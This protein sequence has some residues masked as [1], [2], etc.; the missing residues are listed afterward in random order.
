MVC[1]VYGVW[2]ALHRFW[3]FYLGLVCDYRVVMKA[4]YMAILLLILSSG[5]GY[6]EAYGDIVLRPLSQAPEILPGQGYV[7]ET[8]Y[9]GVLPSPPQSCSLDISGYVGDTWET[10]IV[11]WTCGGDYVEVVVGYRVAEMPRAGLT[12]H[13]MFVGTATADGEVYRLAPTPLH[14][15]PLRIVNH[16]YVSVEAGGYAELYI[17]GGRVSGS[18][19]RMLRGLS[20]TLSSP[21]PSDWVVNLS[22]VAG[23]REIVLARG[24]DRTPPIDAELY[25]YGEV[26]SGDIL[27]YRISAEPVPVLDAT[28]GDA[29]VKIRRGEGVARLTLYVS[30]PPPDPV[31]A[32]I[33]LRSGTSEGSWVG[34][35]GA[36]RYLLTAPVESREEELYL[37]AR[38]VI[39]G[40]EYVATGLVR[41]YAPPRPLDIDLLLTL[42]LWLPLLV[43]FALS[44]LLAVGV[45]TAQGIRLMEYLWHGI[46]GI[47]LLALL[48]QILAL[49]VGYVA[50]YLGYDSGLAGATNLAEL[51]AY[52][53]DTLVEISVEYYSE[54]GVIL[55]VTI[56]VVILLVAIGVVTFG[57]S[58]GLGGVIATLMMVM[59]LGL[60]ANMVLVA[61]LPHIILLLALG[62]FFVAGLRIFISSL[63]LNLRGVVEAG[64]SPILFFVPLI[65][66]TFVAE[67][68]FQAEPPIPRVEIPLDLPLGLDEAVRW[69]VQGVIDFLAETLVQALLITG[70]SVLHVLIVGYVVFHML[71]TLFLQVLSVGRG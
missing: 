14:V 3:G 9:R 42:F 4:L 48:P 41:G 60:I 24:L 38:L 46:L 47:I 16:S 31:E 20:L 7:G 8:I 21:S 53:S 70:K 28:Y 69:A 35:D 63:T 34:I 57:A 56:A 12:M 29:V 68:L 55:G 43:F 36:G 64:L 58:G 50:G 61:V 15:P 10:W 44:L 6:V 2:Y 54:M 52:A 67:L 59:M 37:D 30:I 27:L 32:Y 1:V 17:G 23:W 40:E 18:A 22:S 65:L 62:I 45:F 13:P 51:V 49:G 26:W 66:A 71:Q 25:G 33:R 5:Y 11:D 19:S 39:R